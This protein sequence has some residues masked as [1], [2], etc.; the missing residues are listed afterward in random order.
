MSDGETKVA[1]NIKGYFDK[2]GARRVCQAICSWTEHAWSHRSN[3]AVMAHVSLDCVAVV[4]GGAVHGNAGTELL[5]R[6][7]V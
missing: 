6:S 5:N 4:L 1:G 2:I 3:V 7:Y